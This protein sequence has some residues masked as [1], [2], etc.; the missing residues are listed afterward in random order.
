MES[1]LTLF[2]A[3]LDA[4]VN[5]RRSAELE[6]RKLEGQPGMLAASFQLITAEGVDLS[7]RQAA[8]IYVKNRIATGWDAPPSRTDS[9]RT[10]VPD[11]DL[12]LIHI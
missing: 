3:T 12:S 11:E 2:P 6:L 5:V 9:G 1:L 8:S 10:R 4:D 7:V